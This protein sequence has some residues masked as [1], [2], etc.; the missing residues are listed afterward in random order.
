MWLLRPSDDAFNRDGE[1][2]SYYC[3]SQG[4]KRRVNAFEDPISYSKFLRT[5]VLHPKIVVWR[6]TLQS[7]LSNYRYDV[8]S[9]GHEE[10]CEMIYG[11][12]VF[13]IIALRP[14][15]ITFKLT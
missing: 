15:P 11:G 6:P 12:H 3:S 5:E 14:E 2:P 13:K 4:K 7:M 1:C 10:A 9:C 8:S